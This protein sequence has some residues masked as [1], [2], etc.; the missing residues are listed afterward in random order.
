MH[1]PPFVNHV[2]VYVYITTFIL[3]FLEYGNICETVKHFLQALQ[4][5]LQ[6]AQTQAA[7]SFTN[8]SEEQGSGKRKR[9]TL[10]CVSFFNMHY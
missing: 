10:P 2:F 6:D 3:L 4:A 8:N 5:Q 9:D 7:D 1:I